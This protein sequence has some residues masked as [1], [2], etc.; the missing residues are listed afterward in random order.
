MDWHY[1]KDN[2]PPRSVIVLATMSLSKPWERVRTCRNGC[3]TFDGWGTHV[4]YNFWKPTDD[5]DSPL[6]FSH[7][8]SFDEMFD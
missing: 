3:C 4:N 6:Q 8:P 5:Q 1:W 7:V 2:P